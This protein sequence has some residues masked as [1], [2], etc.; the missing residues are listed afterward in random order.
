MSKSFN[1]SIS[2]YGKQYRG[3]TTTV[4]AYATKLLTYENSNATTQ[5][6]VREVARTMLEYG[7]AAE[8]YFG[9]SVSGGLASN[10][11]VSLPSATVVAPAGFTP[12]D[13][14]AL[15]R[16]TERFPAGYLAI[17]VTCKSDTT[18][19][20][21]FFVHTG[22][23]K[24]QAKEWLENPENVTFDGAAVTAAESGNY[25]VISKQNVAVRDI[26]S[27]FDLVVAGKTYKVSVLDYLIKAQTSTTKDSSGNTVPNTKLRDLTKGLFAYAT[28]AKTLG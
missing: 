27:S 11:D 22:Y 2:A 20:I 14:D 7:K 23:T 17:S 26:K 4:A 24:A 15:K 16:D 13:G 10:N 19:S 1:Y 5:Q 18:L 28:A 12:F 6:R 3:G 21:A 9:V 25:L 8:V